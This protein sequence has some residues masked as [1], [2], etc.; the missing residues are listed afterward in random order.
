VCVCVCVC[1]CARVCVCVGAAIL[2]TL[3]LYSGTEQS[4]SVHSGEAE[5]I[6]ENPEDIRQVM[7]S[8]IFNN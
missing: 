6:Y 2:V 7:H 5:N 8:D 3:P 1:V 4:M